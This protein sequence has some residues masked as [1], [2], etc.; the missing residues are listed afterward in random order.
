M[1]AAHALRVRMLFSGFAPRNVLHCL[2]VCHISDGCL[3]M[4]AGH[5]LCMLLALLDLKQAP[6]CYRALG[7]HVCTTSRQSVLQGVASL[8]TRAVCDCRG[9][10]CS[11][12][13][14]TPMA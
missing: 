2:A 4:H 7:M 1:Q 6:V 11:R 12:H 14:A 13:K 5:S 3:P 10:P 9:R 8:L